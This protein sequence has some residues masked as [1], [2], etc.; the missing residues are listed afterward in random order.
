MV[1]FL[2]SLFI[3]VIGGIAGGLQSI[4]TAT[5]GQKVGELGSVLFTYGIGAILILVIV[6]VGVASGT[7][8]ISQWRTIPR[9]AFFAGPLGIVII[10]SLAYTI[11]R[12]GATSG[13]MLFIVG[14]LVFSAIIDH[15]GWFGT[16]VKPFDITRIAGA[17]ILL[18]GGWLVLK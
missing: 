1:L 2:I 3:G 8:D 5:M 18:L 4:F 16:P 9:W 12:I 7:A 6:S 13:T 17:A 15:F 14:W 10:G 11:P